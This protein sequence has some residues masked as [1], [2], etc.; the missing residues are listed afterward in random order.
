M[1]CCEARKQQLNAI[2]AESPA[3][4]GNAEG[5]EEQELQNTGRSGAEKY[6]YTA[7]VI[8]LGLFILVLAAI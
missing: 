3:G 6:L 5:M 4:I 8:T 2:E 7:A 1:G